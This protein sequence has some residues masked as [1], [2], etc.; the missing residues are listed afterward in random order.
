M[1]AGGRLVRRE[2]RPTSA[3][4]QT[5]CITQPRTPQ[6]RRIP[7]TTLVIGEVEVAACATTLPLAGAAIIGDAP[8]MPKPTV[9]RIA[10]T[11]FFIAFFSAMIPSHCYPQM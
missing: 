2:I 4:Q 8:I 7:Q 3:Y 9:I 5:R 1:L 10:K 11:I 6:T